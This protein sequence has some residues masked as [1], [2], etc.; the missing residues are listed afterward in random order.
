MGEHF[1]NSLY[2]YILIIEEEQ[3]LKHLKE[4]E[5][6]KRKKMIMDENK[7]K[8]AAI[9]KAK[10]GIEEIKPPVKKRKLESN[11]NFSQLNL[12]TVRINDSDEENPKKKKL[13]TNGI[14]SIKS[15]FM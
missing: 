8:L 5:K 15:M 4:I 2:E 13:S 6:K 1:T 12:P 10:N 7:S 3:R 11:Q 9:H 14:R